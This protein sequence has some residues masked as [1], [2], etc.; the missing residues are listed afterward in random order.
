MIY[1][2]EP[3]HLMKK[4]LP[5]IRKSTHSSFLFYRLVVVLHN[6]CVSIYQLHLFYPISCASL[7][8]L[9]DEIRWKTPAGLFEV[10]C[11]LLASPETLGIGFAESHR[12]LS[13]Q[14]DC[15]KRMV[16][17]KLQKILTVDHEQFRF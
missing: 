5:V 7:G 11:E 3:N 6:L 13:E 12:H 15:D 4:R 1:Y 16:M 10:P 17:E 2:E 9:K 14:G 8:V